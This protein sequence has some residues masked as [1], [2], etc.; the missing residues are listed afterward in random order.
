[1]VRN[2]IVLSKSFSEANTSFPFSYVRYWRVRLK[3]QPLADFCNKFN[4]NFE[5]LDDKPNQEEVYVLPAVFLREDK[6]LRDELHRTKLVSG[7]YF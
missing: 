5:P 3:D 6:V 1:M 7:Y 4:C 2:L